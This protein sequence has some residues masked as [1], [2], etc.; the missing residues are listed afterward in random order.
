MTCSTFREQHFAFM[1]GELDP[2]ELANMERHLTEC[3]T[4]AAHDS[5]VRRGILL[6]RNL[7]PIEPSADFSSRLEAR[8][9]AL[10]GRPSARVPT[11]MR[12]Y[13]AT[14][15]GVAAVGYLAVLAFRE[16]TRDHISAFRP[17]S[18]AASEPSTP[19]APTPQTVSMQE[20]RFVALPPTFSAVGST[21]T[22][23]TQLP[24][25]PIMPFGRADLPGAWSRRSPLR[26]DGGAFTT[27]RL[28]R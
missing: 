13:L 5:V 9:G 24:T 2:V 11:K 25:P 4:C 27:V 1:D 23:T 3:A 22:F 21:D 14:A 17:L 18:V 8:L 20:P 26:L 19:P 12:P 28:T 16:P 7:P 6:V 10:S 15:I